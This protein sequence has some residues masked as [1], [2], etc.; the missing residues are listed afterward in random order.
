MS[1]NGNRF[2]IFYGWWIVAA[3]FLIGLY[4]IGVIFYGFTAVFEPIVDEMG[5]SYAQVSFA[6]SLRGA[7]MG[8]LAPFVGILVDRLGPRRLIFSGG[9]FAALGLF[10]LSNATSLT[11][12]Y[13]AYLLMAVGISCCTMTVLMTAIANWFRRKVGIATG[14]V[15]AG[16]G[17]GGLLVPVMVGL[18]EVWG[19]RT[20]VA[21]LA[22]G[23]LVIILPLLLLFRHKPEQYGY[24]PDGQAEGATTIEEGSDQRQVEVNIKAGQAF[25]SSA[26]WYI[27]LAF[28]CQ[29]LSVHA[30]ITHLMPYLSSIGVSRARSQWVATFL[31]LISVGGRLGFGWLGDRVDRR[32]LTAIAFAMM[33]FGLV[34]FGYA[35]TGGVWLLV[36]FAVI[37]GIGY[38]SSVTLRPTLVREYFGRANFGKILGWMVGINMLGGIAGPPLAGWLYDTWGSYQGTWFIFV[39]VALLSLLSILAVRPVRVETGLAGKP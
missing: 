34:C 24:L 28:T 31:P 4:T 10:L 21:I 30:T 25:K 6:A 33:G 8:I 17:S 7:E 38:G 23:M 32:R 11:L 9:I 39:G 16:F 29:V 19:W 26:F 5:W 27:T 20:T 36:P 15:S 12:F 18:I 13:G 2:R 3:S 22:V 14:I 1:F 35:S 37:Y